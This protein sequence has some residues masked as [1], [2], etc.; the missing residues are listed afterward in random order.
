MSNKEI[1]PPLSVVRLVH[2]DKQTPQW[3]SQIGRCFRIG[4]YSQQDETDCVWLV[5]EAG[6]YEQTA[7][8]D[9]LHDYFEIVELS[10]ERSMFGAGCPPISPLASVVER[11]SISHSKHTIS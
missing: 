2:A 9:Q 1:I 11:G 6:E 7:D 4:Y 8:Q 5:N 3:K 10:T